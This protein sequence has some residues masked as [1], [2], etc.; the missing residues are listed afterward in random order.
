M[1]AE[2]QPCD[3]R[4]EP[5][6]PT[7][8]VVSFLDTQGKSY[9]HHL[10]Q[11]AESARFQV[12]EIARWMIQREYAEAL[13]TIAKLAAILIDATGNEGFGMLE[14][15]ARTYC[16]CLRKV[17]ES[18]GLDWETARIDH[19]RALDH[20]KRNY[21]QRFEDQGGCPHVL[22]QARAVFSKKA[23][24]LYESIGLDVNCFTYFLSYRPKQAEIAPFQTSD[25]EVEAIIKRCRSLPE[26]NPEFHKI[27]MLA[28]GCG[29]RSSEIL[30]AQFKHLYEFNGGHFL[31]FPYKTKAGKPQNTG[32]PAAV[33]GALKAYEEDP[34][35]FIIQGTNRPKL[36]QRE[37]IAWLRDEAGI[38]DPRPLHRLRK[39][40]GSRV[41]T[42]HG[43]YAAS[44][45][46]R[47]SSVTT[48]E[49]YY[50]DFIGHQNNVQI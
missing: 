6:G 35:D 44:K 27:Y 14:H 41:A 42:T 23:I 50:A 48:T 36:V 4:I 5:K 19:L 24:R 49:K 9:R 20:L 21:L 46:L 43:I 37:F 47:H 10:E 7:A 15:T 39:I 28:M 3:I 34:C 12:E 2:P 25:V 16:N 11:S 40:L 30:K 18:C 26:E 29:L 8:C 32:I 17:L 13:P 38:N 1:T 22:R 33:F 45:T 31:R